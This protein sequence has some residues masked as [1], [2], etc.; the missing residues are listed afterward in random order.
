ML[1]ISELLIRVKIRAA[2]PVGLSVS[3]PG[4]EAAGP[5]PLAQLMVATAA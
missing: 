5:A 4:L 1:V 3:R 2:N